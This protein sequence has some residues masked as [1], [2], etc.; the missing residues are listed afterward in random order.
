M[1][2][3]LFLCHRIPYPPDKGDK[4]RAWNILNHLS[5]QWEID[6]GCLIDD[7]ADVQ[8]V[9]FLKSRCRSVGAFRMNSRLSLWFQTLRRMKP[10]QPLSVGWFHDPALWN[11]VNERISTRH[12]D[13]VYAFSAAMAPYLV[14][15]NRPGPS[16]RRILDMV[17][18]DSEKWSEYAKNSSP[19]MKFVWRR[20][21][22][23]LLAFERWA[24]RQFDRC[25][26]VSP[27]ERDR[28]GQLAPET[29]E[30]IDW[31]ENGVDMV[32]FSPD[33]QYENP[34]R[35]G[36]PAIVF[37]GTMDY[38]PNVEA[39]TWFATEVMPR[40]RKRAGKYSPTF[41]IVGAKPARSV[42]EL[43]QMPG[44]YV[45][46]AV[47]DVRPYLAHADVAVA[48]LMI[49]RGIQNKVLEAMAL[50]R[51][52]VASPAAFE[53][54]RARPGLDVLV[55]DGAVDTARAV[56]EI[57]DGKWGGLGAAARSTM[58]ANYH[59]SSTLARLDT[60]MA[61]SRDGQ[62]PALGAVA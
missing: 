7:A 6:L 15:L 57:L 2:N 48:P 36:G 43:A 24:A 40:L 26:F 44:V 45:T 4:I 18:V 56:D 53:G 23:T 30:Y 47:P 61:A 31:V 12:Y 11:W 9:P 41:H 3:L 14:G 55:A 16:C 58:L 17:D 5:K 42:S 35:T 32:Y 49:A 54:V 62:A 52:V 38:R 27:K 34:Y 37:T 1:P 10:G 33:R 60:I 50:G 46:G 29:D 19:P 25:I 13:A 8:H 51:P 39:V 22:R 21:G 28:F 20:E 59:W